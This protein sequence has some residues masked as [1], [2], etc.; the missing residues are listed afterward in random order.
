MDRDGTPRSHEEDP[1]KQTGPLG[2]EWPNE[3]E[4]PGGDVLSD[5]W[6][7]G[8]EPAHTQSDE[9]SE[10][11]RPELDRPEDHGD[12]QPPAEG[13]EGSADYERPEGYARPDDGGWVPDGEHDPDAEPPRGFLGSGWTGENDLEEEKGSQNKR[14]ILAMVAIVVLAVAGGWIVSSSVGSRSEA[15]CS[16]PA[17]CSPVGQQEPAPTDSL[18]ADPS[19]QPT[20]TPEETTASPSETPTSAS[21]T[22]QARVT[23]QPSARP[24]PT[25]TRVRSPEPS[26]RSSSTPQQPD[27][28]RIEDNPT[29]TPSTSSPAPPP[30]AP[31]TQAP[32]PSPTKTKSAGLLDWLF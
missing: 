2:I 4:R 27:E 11:E 15:A 14:L 10:F 17:D 3:P 23:H 18:P 9:S 29:A 28:P 13:P 25:H 6:T 5:G 21:P 12:H 20:V 32:A 26:P 19:T 22:S 30:P 8:H 7:P 16:A 1:L 24:S 31:T